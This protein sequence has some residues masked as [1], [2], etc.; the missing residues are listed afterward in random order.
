MSKDW[1]LERLESQEYLRG[2]SFARKMYRAYTP[3]W[4][5]D[6]CAACWQKLVEPGVPADDAVHEGY[7]T[8]DEYDRGAE[9]EWVCVPC[10]ETFARDMDW[11]D[12]TKRNSN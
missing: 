6:H 10:F 9:Y 5:H 1:R 3:E 4:E 12:L 11:R 7:A 2:V 8:T